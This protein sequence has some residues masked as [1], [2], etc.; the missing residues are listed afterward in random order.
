LQS[1]ALAAPDKIKAGSHL[2]AF[3][4]GFRKG[5]ERQPFFAKCNQRR[6]KN[7]KMQNSPPWIVWWVSPWFPGAL[8]KRGGFREQNSV[9]IT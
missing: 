2:L 9:V 5:A 7:C 4:Q 3:A 6:G 1:R 8:A